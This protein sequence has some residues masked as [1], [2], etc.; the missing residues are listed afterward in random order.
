MNVTQEAMTKLA[1]FLQDYDNGFV[2]VV[3][4]AKGAG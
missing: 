4:A 3:R 2:R 1:E